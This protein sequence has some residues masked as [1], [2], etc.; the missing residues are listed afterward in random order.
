VLRVVLPRALVAVGASGARSAAL[1]GAMTAPRSFSPIGR[2][3]ENTGGATLPWGDKL[4]YRPCS[5]GATDGVSIADLFKA[6][7]RSVRDVHVEPAR[8]NDSAALPVLNHKFLVTVRDGLKDEH[9]LYHSDGDWREF[10]GVR[11]L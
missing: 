4:A 7:L 3:A 8:F 1:K 6:T 9:P 11:E 2:E 10:K 5:H